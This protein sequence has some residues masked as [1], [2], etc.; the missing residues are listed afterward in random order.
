[1]FQIECSDEGTVVLV[2]RLDAAQSP[3]ADAFLL[4]QPEGSLNLVLSGLEYIS[5]AGLGILLKTH[6]RLSAAGHEL[7]LSDVGN[8][9]ADIFRYSG[10]DRLFKITTS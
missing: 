7:V 6:K 10:F 3:R 2:G 4:E 5:S 1:M 9:L 8:H